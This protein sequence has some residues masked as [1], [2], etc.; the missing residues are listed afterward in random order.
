MIKKIYGLSIFMT[1]LEI[2]TIIFKICNLI[3]WTW[4]FVFWGY[5]AIFC[6]FLA[7]DLITLIILVKTILKK[8]FKREKLEESYLL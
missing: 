1:F 7:L 3:L 8:I 4:K 5:W 2:A 6:V